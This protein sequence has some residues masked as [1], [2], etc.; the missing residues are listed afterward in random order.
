MK[1][2]RRETVPQPLLELILALLR[3]SC[4]TVVQ[5]LVQLTVPQGQELIWVMELPWCETVPT[6]RISVMKLLSC[7]TVPPL[8]VESILALG[9]APARSACCRSTLAEPAASTMSPALCGAAA[10]AGGFATAVFLVCR[11]AASSRT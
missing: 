5:L 6:V 2:V 8:L 9:L 7:E 11:A 1:L 4:Q 3:P 10:T